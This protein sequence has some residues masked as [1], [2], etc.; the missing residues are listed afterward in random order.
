MN[1]IFKKIIHFVY[2]FVLNKNGKI[3]FDVSSI[4]LVKYGFR[5]SFYS[6]FPCDE[7]GNFL[8]W[9]TYPAIEFLNR[10][11]FSKSSVFEWGSGYSTLYWCNKAATIVSIEDN[12]LWFKKIFKLIKTNVN[13]K[14]IQEKNKY[15]DSIK[16]T[17]HKFDVIIIDGAY[18]E[19]CITQSVKYLKKGGIIILDNSDWYQISSKKL[20]KLGFIE[21]SFAGFSP[22]NGYTLSTSIFIKNTINIEYKKANHPIG[23][24]VQSAE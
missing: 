16:K 13:L 10:L 6:G 17:G 24:L 22:L 4:L 3:F 14:L 5:K 9:Y 7:S 15:I 8:P 21:I 23:G 11:D 1:L 20:R 19:K 2:R 18:R 12:K